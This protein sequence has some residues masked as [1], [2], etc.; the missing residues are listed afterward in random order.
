M[1]SSRKDLQ[2]MREEELDRFWEIDALLPKRTVVPHAR[3]TSAVEIEIPASKEEQGSTYPIP[4]R[5]AQEEKDPPKR[6]Y[7]PPHKPTVPPTP[8]EEYVPENALLRR[9]RIYPWN[10]TYRYY[11]DFF[12]DAVRLYPI[13][14]EECPRISFFS[15]VP[16][17]SQMSRAQLE[18]Y[19]WWRDC[20]R[21]GVL[22]ETDYSYLLLHAYELI[23]LSRKL[24]PV[25]VQGELCKLWE[26]YRDTY[27]QLDSYLPEW[28]CDCS[29][30]HRLPPP[31]W[32]SSALQKA[33]MGHCRF[34]EFYVNASREEGYARALLAFCC[35]YDYRKSKFCT[36]E[37]RPLF[38]RAIL[39]VIGAAIDATEKEGQLFFKAGFEDSRMSRDAYSGALCVARVKRRIEIEY[40]SFSRSHELRYFLTDLVKYTENA[41]RAALGIRSRLTVYSLPMQ[42]RSLADSILEG[43][44]PRKQCRE[45]R[46]A[47]EALYD[48]PKHSLSF[49][50]AAEIEKN[51]WETTDLLL[52]AFGEDENQESE[53]LRTESTPD[54]ASSREPTPIA[55]PI[56]SPMP[57]NAPAP[58][59]ASDAWAA[60]RPYLRAVAARDGEAQRREAAL[61]G[62]PCDVLADEINALAVDHFGDLLLEE[63]DGGYAVIE[64]YTDWLETLLREQT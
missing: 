26:S 20:F 28:I 12:R 33:A 2:R 47:Y 27:R 15:Y 43:I 57:E 42:I 44:L 17:Y 45:E 25:L 53:E 52:E 19:L 38:D 32:S 36:E 7:I 9:V 13:R 37:Q 49:E 24:D 59:D 31:V 22:L 11:E 14:G 18:W 41:I 56:L 62:R 39:A 40:C 34:R 35:N 63:A 30:L 46:E 16:Q 1:D 61:Q 64:D 4:P 29:L 55:E 50:A 8:S 23:N 21:R 58:S 54:S 3:D 51:S 60:Y 48:L 5:R 6:H 10:S